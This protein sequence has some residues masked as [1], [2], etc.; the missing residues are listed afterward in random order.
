MNNYRLLEVAKY[1]AEIYGE[2]GW[3]NEHYTRYREHWGIH[4][5]IERAVE[6]VGLWDQFEAEAH[7]AGL[8][9]DSHG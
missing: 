9:Q 1:V 6:A 2:L 5:S 8:W 4:I 3:F 7:S